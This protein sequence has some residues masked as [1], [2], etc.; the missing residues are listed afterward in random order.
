MLRLATTMDFEFGVCGA[1]LPGAAV[2]K[3]HGEWLGNAI[4]NT[5]ET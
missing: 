3:W 1:C 5:K 2:M 4:E